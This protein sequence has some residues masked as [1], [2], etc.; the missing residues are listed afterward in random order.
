MKTLNNLI[1]RLEKQLEK[2]E[3]R[4]AL[5][6]EAL[7]DHR[8]QLIEWGICEICGCKNCTSDHK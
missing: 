5:A 3:K 7:R 6:E 4:A 1:L 8:N 2:S